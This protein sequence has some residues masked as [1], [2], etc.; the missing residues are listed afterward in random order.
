MIFNSCKK[1]IKGHSHMGISFLFL[2][3]FCCQ[4]DG[5]LHLL[6]S[7]RATKSKTQKVTSTAIYFTFNTLICLRKR[8]KWHILIAYNPNW[9]KYL[10]QKKKQKNS[11][12]VDPSLQ[13]CAH[14]FRWVV[15]I[16]DPHGCKEGAGRRAVQSKCSGTGLGFPLPLLP[17]NDKNP[18][19][20]FS[21]ENAKLYL[22]TLKHKKF[23]KG[24]GTPPPQIPPPH[25]NNTWLKYYTSVAMFC[26]ANVTAAIQGLFTTLPKIHVSPFCI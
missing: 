9:K 22:I 2:F 17:S 26:F 16:R 7:R 13:F 23:P 20:D 3:F 12:I 15:S 6:P 24:K 4:F 1:R 25:E 11:G 18:L 8:N 10:V 5:H 19:F 14:F 21:V